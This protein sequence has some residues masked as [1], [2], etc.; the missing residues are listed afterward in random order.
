MIGHFKLIFASLAVV[1]AIANLV[2]WRSSKN[3][4]EDCATPGAL[5]FDQAIAQCIR[6]RRSCRGECHA[7]DLKCQAKCI[8]REKDY[9]CRE[10]VFYFAKFDSNQDDHVGATEYKSTMKNYHEKEMPEDVA[11]IIVKNHDVNRDGKLSFGEFLCA[12]R[13]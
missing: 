6:L 1:F 5:H 9:K 13:I 4:V 12:L 3:H 8:M 10:N 7:R 11:R 2:Q